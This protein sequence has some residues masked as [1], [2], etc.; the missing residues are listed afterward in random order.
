MVKSNN[1]TIKFI[2]SAILATV[3][4]VVT[5]VISLPYYKGY[6]MVIN[7]DVKSGWAIILSWTW[8]IYCVSFHVIMGWVDRGK[9]IKKKMDNMDKTETIGVETKKKK[10]NT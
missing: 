8:L 2:S 3:A 10:N 7:D 6:L 9:L 4:L 1:D 5:F